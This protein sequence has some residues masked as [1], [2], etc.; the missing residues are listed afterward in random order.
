M[1]RVGIC[2]ETTVDRQSVRQIVLQTLFRYDEVSCIEY[3]D[4]QT[5]EQEICEGCLALDLLIMEINFAKQNGIAIATQIRG[6]KLDID[7]IFVTHEKM[8][9]FDGYRVQAQGYVLKDRLEQEL[10]RCLEDY[11]GR[12]YEDSISVKCDSMMKTI[13]I[14]SLIYVE[15]DARTLIMHTRGDNIRVYGKLSDMEQ[16]LQPYGFIRIHQS[17]LVKKSM[18]CEFR[19]SELLLGEIKLPVSRRYYKEVMNLYHPACQTQSACRM[20]D[21][22]ITKSLAFRTEDN[23]AI[24]GTKGELLGVIY[25][26]KQ[27]EQLRLGREIRECQIV[28]NNPNVSRVHCIV[29]RVENDMYKLEDCSKNGVYVEGKLV[30]KGNIVDA[31]EGDRVCICDETIEFRLG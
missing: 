7:I 11:I 25:R 5:L 27:G 28:I 26:M 6:L 20:N 24:I 9:V 21:Y 8:H 1:L 13:A 12:Y 30:G 14:A 18:I 4:A 15:S 29:T 17:Y 3:A 16:K 2:D 10:P 23:G 31:H 22:T 19:G